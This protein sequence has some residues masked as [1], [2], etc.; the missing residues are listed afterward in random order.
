[1]F[2]MATKILKIKDQLLNKNV[3]MKANAP[4]IKTNLIISV[5]H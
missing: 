5:Y 4:H 1:M 2:V 3:M